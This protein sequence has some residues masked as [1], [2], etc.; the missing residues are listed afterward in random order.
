MVDAVHSDVA[1]FRDDSGRVQVAR[2]MVLEFVPTKSHSS[3]E[4]ED[5]LGKNRRFIADTAWQDLP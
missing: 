1:I 2:E 3:I 4:G 5:R